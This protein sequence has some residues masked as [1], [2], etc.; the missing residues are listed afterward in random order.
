MTSVY[1]VVNDVAPEIETCT[2]RKCNFS[3]PGH[4][5]VTNGIVNRLRQCDCRF[6][7]GP[8]LI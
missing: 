1:D 2:L 7:Y 3:K 6:S 4:K 8:E 5:P